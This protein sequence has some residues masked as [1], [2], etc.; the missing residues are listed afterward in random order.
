MA[1]R[2]AAALDSPD[3]LARVLPHMPRSPSVGAPLPRVAVGLSGGVDSAVAA[4]LLKT[5]GFDVTGVL[6]RNWDEAEETGGACDF[7]RDRRDAL[8]V[9]A[10]LRG[11]KVR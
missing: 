9:V 3:L 8:A 7:E 2:L 1:S 4:W 11:A 6:M 10:A 5:A